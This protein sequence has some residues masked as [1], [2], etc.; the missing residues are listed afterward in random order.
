MS[1]RQNPLEAHTTKFAL[2]IREF[3]KTLPMTVSNV[4]DLKNL[5]VSSGHIGALYISALG[6]P[7]RNEYLVRLKSCITETRTTHYWLGLVDTQGA[8]PLDH[9]RDQ[10]QQAAEELAGV[11]GKV[12]QSSNATPS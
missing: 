3:A 5:V 4:E 7:N 6:A 12:I 8:A 11:F 10:L 9:R 2:A 1:E